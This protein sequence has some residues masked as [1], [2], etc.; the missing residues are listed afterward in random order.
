M[1]CTTT[2]QFSAI[3]AGATFIAPA[4]ADSSYVYMKADL[5][6]ISPAP[7]QNAILLTTGVLLAIGPTAPF[8]VLALKV[9]PA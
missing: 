6:G 2:T 1:T 7:A 3:P 4:P 8:V 9:V 5:T